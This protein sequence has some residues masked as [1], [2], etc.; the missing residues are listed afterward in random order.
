MTMF[1]EPSEEP[2][3]GDQIA[4]DGRHGLTSVPPQMISEV[5]DIPGRDPTDAEPF[6]VG[7]W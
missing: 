6:A 3:N 7:W 2:A 5:G 1:G 4:V